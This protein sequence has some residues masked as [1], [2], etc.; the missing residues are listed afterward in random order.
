MRPLV[1][2]FL[3]LSITSIAQQIEYRGALELQGMYASEELPFWMYTN[4]NTRANELTN[5][6]GYAFAKA[7]YELNDTSNIEVG[8]GLMYRDGFVDRFQR[9]ELF[10]RYTN[11]WLQATVGSKNPEEAYD[12]LSTSN[13]NILWSGNNRAIPGI[14]LEAPRALNIGKYFTLDYGFGHYSLNDDRYVDDTRVHYKKLGIGINLSPKHYFKGTL[15]HYAQWGGT[16]PILGDLPAGFSDFTKVIFAQNAGDNAEF[17]EQVNALGNHLG[18]F[19]FEYTY[20]GIKGSFTAYH[21]HLFEDGSGTAFKNFPD[22]IWGITYAPKDKK[23]KRILYE[24]VNTTDQSAG[25]GRS[26]GD[27]YFSN[28]GYRSG[29]TYEGNTIGLPFILLNPETGLGISNNLIKAHHLGAFF[30]F[31][32]LD[33]QLKVSA[34]DDAGS[35]SNR[36]S[37]SIKKVY[38]YANGTYATNY[39]NITLVVGA[40]TSSITDNTLGVGLGYQYS[41]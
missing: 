29:W 21:L 25:E 31:D 39:G 8:L 22:G 37:S 41:F 35:P 16:H 24:Y 13:G 4:T 34:V 33:L 10:V 7:E 26:S 27:N 11:T 15:Q 40:D 36:L 6:S 38:T 28:K 3:F 19:D 5:V 2:L 30:S 9:N 23:L 17:N 14:T 18:S 1:I 12:G 20:T 32:K